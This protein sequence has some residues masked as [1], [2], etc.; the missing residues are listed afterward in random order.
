MMWVQKE[1][2]LGEDAP[3]VETIESFS[4]KVHAMTV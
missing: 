3:C 4:H 2:G 1:V